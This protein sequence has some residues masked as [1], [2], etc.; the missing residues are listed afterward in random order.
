MK[1]STRAFSLN[2]SISGRDNGTLECAYIRIRE[3]KVAKTVELRESALLVDLDSK[4]EALGFEILAPV[5]LSELKKKIS[6]KKVSKK[7]SDIFTRFIKNSVPP[8]LVT[9]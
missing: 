3:G 2:V 5:K 4:G 7:D 1:K 6:A 8:G 9:V